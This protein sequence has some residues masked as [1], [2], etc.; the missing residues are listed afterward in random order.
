MNDDAIPVIFAC[1]MKTNETYL[2]ETVG[3]D[4]L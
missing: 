2:G 3:H 1:P 4:A